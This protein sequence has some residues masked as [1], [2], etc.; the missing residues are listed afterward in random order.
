MTLIYVTPFEGLDAAT[1]F[2]DSSNR[3]ASTCCHLLVG[4]TAHKQ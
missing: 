3:V 1:F 4:N 2:F